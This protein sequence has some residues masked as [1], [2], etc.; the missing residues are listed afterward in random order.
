MLATS[1]GDAGRGGAAQSHTRT[2]TSDV[3]PFWSQEPPRE[4]RETHREPSHTLLQALDQA[5]T[6]CRAHAHTACPVQCEF[7]ASTC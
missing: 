6:A 1:G 7:Y 4:V 3:Q 5:H 2:C